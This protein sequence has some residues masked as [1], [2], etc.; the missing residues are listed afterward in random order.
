MQ[1]IQTAPGCKYSIVARVDT[2]IYSPDQTWTLDIPAGQHAFIAKTNEII[3][4]GDAMICQ[5]QHQ[6]EEDTASVNI[7]G[8]G[9]GSMATFIA[10][11]IKQI[12]GKG[13][14]TVEYG[15]GEL[16]VHTDRAD[17]AQYA[18]V[19]DILDRFVP[20]DVEVARYNHNIEIS[21][22]NI[23]KYAE[24]KTILEVSKLNAE[25]WNDVT[26]DGQWIYPLTNATSLY[27]N[28]NFGYLGFFQNTPAT[29]VTIYTPNLTNAHYLFCANTKTKKVYI[30]APSLVASNYIFYNSKIEEIE[31]DLSKLVSSNWLAR[32]NSKLRKFKCALSSFKTNDDL[33]FAVA[34]LDKESAI[35][36]LTSI[37]TVSG[38]QLGI[39]IHTDHK[40]DEDV[41]AAKAKAEAKGWKINIRWNGTPTSTASTFDMGTL[42]YAKAAETKRPDGT[43]EKYLSWGHYVTDWE[44]RGY[45]IFRNLTSAYKY[46]NLEMSENV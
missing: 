28:P 6:T 15:N 25:W 34:Q 16:V 21:W 29:S 23:N 35:T 32:N 1:L 8:E 10:R 4:P 44:A 19:T 40:T 12:V 27:D 22:R 11:A 45:E 17:A 13:N 42:I 9:A 30:Y 43:T 37:P 5:K 41:L 39:G 3:I 7:L 14:M 38:A 18:A 2:T 36:I 46:F 26:S 20:K 24:C 31:G 33:A